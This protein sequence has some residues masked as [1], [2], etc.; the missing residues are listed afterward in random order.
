MPAIPSK[1]NSI[2]NSSSV[3]AKQARKKRTNQID[4]FINKHKETMVYW[5][6]TALYYYFQI[7]IVLAIAF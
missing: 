2:S 6:N 1:S 3:A 5:K 7:S 4:L